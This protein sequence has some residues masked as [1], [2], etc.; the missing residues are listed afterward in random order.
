MVSTIELF[1]IA[2]FN[3]GADNHWFLS[4]HFVPPCLY[5]SSVPYFNRRKHTIQVFLDD[6][7]L[8]LRARFSSVSKGEQSNVKVGSSVGS[9][10]GSVL[11]Q[12]SGCQ[13][14]L[15]YIYNSASEIIIHPFDLFIGLQK[16]YFEICLYRNKLPEQHLT[17]YQHKNL[18]GIFD[19]LIG[20]LRQVIYLEEFGYYC[21]ALKEKD[22]I[23]STE[24][25]HME[26]AMVFYLAVHHENQTMLNAFS[27][28]ARASSRERVPVLHQQNLEGVEFSEVTDEA[29]KARIDKRLSLDEPARYF[30]ILK[31]DE[32]Q[33]VVD[34]L[35]FGFY[36]QNSY[37]DFRF[38]LVS[39]TKQYAFNG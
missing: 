35:S 26:T 2:D 13:H 31:K 24:I 39:E 15:Y 17:H 1:K 25:K 23:Y 12:L 11:S 29:I 38:F 7:E 9:A 18:S 5:L 32:W 21:A 34:H 36:G 16:L 28:T 33:F 37:R 6:F 8:D 19:E 4:E 22:G 10:L 3:K 14:L 27:E 30:E 20:L